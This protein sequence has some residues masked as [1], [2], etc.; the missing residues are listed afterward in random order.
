[1]AYSG[2]HSGSEVD[3]AIGVSKGSGTGFIVKTGTGSGAKR[4]LTAGSAYISIANGNGVS[5]NP[6][7]DLASAVKT[8]LG[9]ADTAVQP[10][11]L[12]PVATS[13]AYSDLTG[14]PTLGSAAAEDTSAFATAAQ[15]ALADTALQSSDINTLSELNAIL[16]DATL[17]NTNDSRLSDSRTPLSHAA[18]HSSGGGDPITPASIGAATS[19]QGALADTA[20]Q[21][22]RQVNSG[23]GLTGGGD[24]SANRTLS[25]DSSTIAS[26]ALADT[27]LQPGDANSIPFTVVNSTQS[28]GLAM[29]NRELQLNSGS[30]FTLTIPLNSSE[31]FPLGTKISFLG[32]GVGVVTIQAASSV[33]LNGVDNGS[34][35]IEQYKSAVITKVGTDAWVI[36]GSVGDVA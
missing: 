22:S 33:D 13:G 31:A 34:T 18:S 8:S 1:M 23:T 11:D 16:S 30:D 24:L 7:I 19:A 9:L 10:G 27:A 36:I 5:A 21:P 25:L 29:S 3:D 32:V 20:V 14:K 4:D 6:A 28:L 12:A 35:T 26:L 15:G 2:A 17:I